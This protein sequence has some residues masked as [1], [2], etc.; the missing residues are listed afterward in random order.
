LVESA[1]QAGTPITS[2]RALQR[3]GCWTANMSLP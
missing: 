2:S 1:F 3:K